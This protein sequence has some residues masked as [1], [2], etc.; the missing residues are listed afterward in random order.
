MDYTPDTTSL[1]I[2]LRNRPTTCESCLARV[3]RFYEVTLVWNSFT[4][5]CHS[6][7]YK[8]KLAVDDLGPWDTITQTIHDQVYEPYD[9]ELVQL[10]KKGERI[11][12]IKRVREL[13]GY[14]TIPGGE[15]AG[16]RCWKKGLKECKE[17]MERIERLMNLTPDYK[18]RGR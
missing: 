18:R 15:G 8:L 13:G 12:A 2:T 10:I 11:K 14:F 5:L 3:E 1:S 9:D 4:D 16:D 7:L 6:C 17:E